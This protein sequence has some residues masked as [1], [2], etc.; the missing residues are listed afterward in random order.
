MKITEM[1]KLNF[2]QTKPLLLYFETSEKMRRL[3]ELQKGSLSLMASQDKSA[4]NQEITPTLAAPSNT[5]GSMPVL[6]DRA[7]GLGFQGLP[8]N[9]GSYM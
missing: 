3:Q 9:S 1:E 4:N 6:P 5:P 2:K 8:E 7:A